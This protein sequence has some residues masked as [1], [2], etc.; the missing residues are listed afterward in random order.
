MQT[1]QISLS[2]LFRLATLHTRKHFSRLLFIIISIIIH[3]I[4]T[5]I[6]TYRNSRLKQEN[7]TFCHVNCRPRWGS[8]FSPLLFLTYNKR[9][10]FFAFPPPVDLALN[11][12][13][14]I[15]SVFACCLH[16][17]VMSRGR[18]GGGKGKYL[19]SS[20]TFREPLGRHPLPF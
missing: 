9:K 4:H 1:L 7:L 6:Q 19:S 16:N 14:A 12:V 11:Q 15:V 17:E 8:T 3:I 20:S 18:G 13:L 5:Y 10:F 2:L